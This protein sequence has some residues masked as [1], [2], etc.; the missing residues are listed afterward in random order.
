M[1]VVDGGLVFK[2]QF[3]IGLALG[4][5]RIKVITLSLLALD[6]GLKMVASSTF[7]GTCP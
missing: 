4:P 7:S 6:C 3:I 2:L 5:R 1:V